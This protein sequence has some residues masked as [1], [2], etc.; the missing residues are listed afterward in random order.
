MGDQ[1]K[2]AAEF[3]QA[4]FKDLQRR[5]VEVIRRLIQQQQ[6]GRLE[7]ELRDQNARAFAS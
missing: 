6:I 7:H 4:L 3:E 5:N 2:G 1:H